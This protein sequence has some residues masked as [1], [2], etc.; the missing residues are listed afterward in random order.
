MK[1]TMT[2]VLMLLMVTGFV[3]AAPSAE[4]GPKKPE[5][6][7][8]VIPNTT[9]MEPMERIFEE[10]TA[11]TGIEVELQALPAG[12]EYGRLLQTRFATKDF[13]DLFTMDPGT[14]QYTKFGVDR[15]LEMTG[16]PLFENVLDASLDFQLYQGKIYGAPWGGTGTYGVYYNKDVFAAIGAD[17]PKNYADFLDIL[18]KA[19]AAGYI[20]IYEAAKSEWP[21]QV[22][23]LIAWPTFVD[24]A[25]GAEGVRKLEKNELRLNE[26]PALKDVFSRYVALRDAG[27]F[28]N[29]YQSGT[30][31]EQM[32]MLATGKAAVAFQISNFIPSLMGKFGEDYISEKIGWF[33]LPSDTDDGVAMLTPAHQILVPAEGKYTDYAMDLVR[34]MTEVENQNIYFEYNNGIPVYKGVEKEL[35][36]YEE[37]VLSYDQ[38]G[39]AKIN[40]QNR[41]SSSFTDFPKILQNLLI[42]S[43]VEEAV[44]MMDENYRRTGKAR[45]LPGF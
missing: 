40:I 8:V 7:T 6:L 26:I 30:Y 31:D 4:K 19:K 43:N 44:N 11:K 23:S 15:L 36:P 14:K 13:P 39:K 32:E 21:L 28:Q 18:K 2:I 5:S 16:D 25:I 33:P 38:A 45:A 24:P 10:Y 35:L 1:K 9:I 12:E 42:T 3:F 34:F 27:L 29:N 37:T 20:P 41:L 17:V 22:F